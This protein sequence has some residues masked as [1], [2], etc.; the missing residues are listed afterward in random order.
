MKMAQFSNAKGFSMVELMVAML[1]GL[2]ILASVS[3]VLVNSKRNYTTQDSMARLQENARFA[4]Q[5][6]S[7]D[8]RAAG[9]FGCADEISTVHNQ[10]NAAASDFYIFDTA[11]AVEGSESKGTWQPSGTTNS[12]SRAGTDGISVRY[13][14]NGSVS[15]T[16][17]MTTE[18]ASMQ[19]SSTS[20]LQEG[21]IIMVADCSSAD[22]F[23]VSSF[24][25]TGGFD[26]L[27]HNPGN[28]DEWP[29]NSG[30]TPHK[31]SKMYGTDAKILKFNSIYY[32]VDTGASGEPALFRQ[33]LKNKTVG[34]IQGYYPEKQE[35]V[36]GIEDLEVLY[37]VDTNGN[38]KIPDRY[39]KA[40][41]M[42]AADWNNLVSVRFGILARTL[43]NSDMGTN[44]QYGTD[45][46]TTGY[47]VD[48]DGSADFT[49][50]ANVDDRYQRRVF[51]T[52]VVLRNLQ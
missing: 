39:K 43:A 10:L 36:E 24:N 3:V 14:D 7:H 38:D 28:G 35:L 15:I 29:G 5:L 52:T 21:D 48:G 30:G 16:K 8:L 11:N 45:R 26:H 31:L 32:Y 37:G 34:G 18:A 49:P 51:R 46:D 42:V 12:L 20:G 9:Y 41:A 23:Q 17:E 47:D 1:I 4:I 40:D 44:K 25:L 22:I 6:M 27:V 19:V 33:T 2:M 50:T 13:A